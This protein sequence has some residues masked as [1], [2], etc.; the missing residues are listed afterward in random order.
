MCYSLHSKFSKFSNPIQK[1][2]LKL[3]DILKRFEG[4]M[5]LDFENNILI[6]DYHL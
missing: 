6:K 5:V 2:G 3:I 4:K 1:E